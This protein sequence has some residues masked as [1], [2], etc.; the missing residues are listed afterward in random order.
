MST[1]QALKVSIISFFKLILA[2]GFMSVAV[3]ALA[4]NNFLKIRHVNCNSPHGPTINQAISHALPGTTI[5]LS[6]D[7]VEN[8]VLNKGVTLDGKGTATLTPA[9]TAQPTIWVA[10]RNATITGLTLQNQPDNP[11]IFVTDQSLV[12]IENNDITGS[13]SAVYVVG[14]SF[15]TIVGNHIANNAGYAISALENSMLR[16]G[17]KTESFPTEIIPNLIENNDSGVLVFRANATVTG[18]KI[19][20]ND[21]YGVVVV[22]SGTARVANNEIAGNDIGLIVATN[23]SVDLATP[24]SGVLYGDPNYGTNNILSIYCS[25]G[26]IGDS[27]GPNFLPFAQ[28]IGTCENATTP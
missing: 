5:V 24:G 15:A 13:T 9:D 28:F 17:F 8:V 16:V 11:H 27:I 10:A 14:S 22:R 12:T 18:N 23:G 21:A 25:S 26:Y 19:I 2:V 4:Q 3:S 1:M 20:N 7:C 6:G